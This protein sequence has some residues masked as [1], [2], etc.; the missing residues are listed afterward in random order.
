[1]TDWEKMA[2][3]RGYADA[4]EMLTKEYEKQRSIEALS[5]ELNISRHVIR[6]ALERHG[7]IVKKQGG[8]QHMKFV[9][10]EQVLDLVEE[11]GIS[12]V[13]KRLGLDYSTVYKRTKKALRERRQRRAESEQSAAA[14]LLEKGTQRHGENQ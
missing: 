9:L 2:K 8:P 14:S 1:M 4:K 12:I 7:V 3:D 11:L 6:V 13:A 10:T 5:Q